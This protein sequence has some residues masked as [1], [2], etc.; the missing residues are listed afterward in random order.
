MAFALA[1]TVPAYVAPPA[2]ASPRPR[3]VSYGVVEGGVA[4]GTDRVVVFVDG[5]KAGEE[6]AGPTG[7]R[8]RVAIPP[9][10]VAVRV[11]A[12]DALGNSAE[13]RVEPVL[14]L[15]AGDQPGRPPEAHEDAPLAR[16]VAALVQ[17]FRGVAAVY[18]E[19]LRT[20]AG[21]AWNARARFP[22]ASTVKVAIAI[23]VLRRLRAR[24]PPGSSLDLLL[25]R[26]LIESDNE[27]AN[28]L[29][30][31]IGG[32]QEA[33]AARV[34]SMLASLGVSE[35]VL[36][37]GFLTAGAQGRPI[38]LA[39]EEQPPTVGKATTAY[40]LART[41]ELVHLAAA[42][43]GAL[44]RLVPGSFSRGDARFLLFQLAHS[45][46]RGKLDRYTADDA[47]VAH[48]GGWIDAARHDAGLV[49]SPSGVFVAAV[50]T[51][52]GRYAGDASDDLAGRIA[53]AASKRLAVR[54]GTADPAT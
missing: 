52:T 6:A 20:G 44:V 30:A 27:A 36:Y 46:D 47:V 21:A 33:G 32:S 14:G 26:M 12:E 13:S 28:A 43:R 15:P 17:R 40:D 22:A 29:L 50:L 19:D 18:V 24:P 41:F 49:Y 45:A 7:F 8:L 34:T 35:T 5:R 38:P 42:G 23:E 51:W 11:V 16:D 53:E 25:E 31:W 1:P 3:E 54:P 9:R 48:K 39:V 10:D 37:G 2:L 4:R